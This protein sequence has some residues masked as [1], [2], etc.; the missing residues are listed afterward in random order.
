MRILLADDHH[1]VRKG[2]AY[3]LEAHPDI[4]IV[5]EASNGEEAVALYERHRPDI[6][7]M[8][9][10]MPVMDGIQATHVILRNHPQAK[11]FMLSG[12]G[13]KDFV[14]QALQAGA[15]GYQLKDVEPD[16]LIHTIQAANSG[17][18]PLDP[19]I[20]KHVLTHVARPANSVADKVNRLT[21]REVDV[22]K[23][24]STGKSNKEIAAALFISEKTVKTHVSNLL[25]KLELQDRT[26]AALFAIQA[27]IAKPIS[28]LD[29]Q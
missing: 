17:E 16:V 18:L 29:E 3:F 11:V 20:M 8:D 2:L 5:A 13:E 26:Q 27:G 28:F 9:I 23:E 4:E 1:V 10:D 25:G 15:C 7:L 19:R 22:L 12:Y 6:L 24:I 21:D 14:I